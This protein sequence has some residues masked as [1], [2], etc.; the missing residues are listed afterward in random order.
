MGG[1]SHRH[2]LAESGTR[3][4]RV[5]DVEREVGADVKYGL[6]SNA[7]LDLTLNTDFAQVEADNQ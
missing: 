3:Y 6:S 1:L 2:V 5:A 7:T 4:E